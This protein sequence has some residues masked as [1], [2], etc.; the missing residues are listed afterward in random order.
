MAISLKII[1]PQRVSKSIWMDGLASG[2]GEDTFTV[3]S[4]DQADLYR[5]GT[6]TK[7]KKKLCGE[8][9]LRSD[10]Q[11]LAEASKYHSSQSLE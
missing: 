1:G 9:T 6:Y 5:T 11:I 8:K 4:K 3:Y 7:K 10:T 2:C